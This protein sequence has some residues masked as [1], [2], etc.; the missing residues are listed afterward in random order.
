MMVDGMVAGWN[1]VVLIHSAGVSNSDRRA[2]Q[3][4]RLSPYGARHLFTTTSAIH[5]CPMDYLD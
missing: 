4:G 2:R 3:N 5:E 1:V